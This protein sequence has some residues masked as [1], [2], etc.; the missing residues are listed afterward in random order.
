M[1]RFTAQLIKHTRYFNWC[2]Y[3]PEGKGK[4]RA[5]KQPWEDDEKGK[6]KTRELPG[7]RQAKVDVMMH[8]GLGV[9]TEELR[10]RS[11][12]ELL[13]QQLG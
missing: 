1:R 7:V 12:A 10:Y 6:A 13:S 8:K 4:R 3:E 2:P 5:G 9:D 11:T